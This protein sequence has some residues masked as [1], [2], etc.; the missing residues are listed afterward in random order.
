M[1]RPLQKKKKKKKKKMRGKT[2]LAMSVSWRLALVKDDGKPKVS[3]ASRQV[4]FDED[5]LA[6]E[7]PVS[8]DGLSPLRAGGRKLLV[9]ETKALCNAL[10]NTASV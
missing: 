2:D 10:R 4:V 3:D 6:L 9:Q 7:V 1:A 5:I 8:D